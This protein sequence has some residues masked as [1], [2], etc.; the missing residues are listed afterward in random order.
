MKA[1]GTIL[2]AGIFASLS[3]PA[4]AGRCM[5]GSRDANGAPRQTPVVVDLDSER[6]LDPGAL[7]ERTSAVMCARRSIVPRPN[8]IRVLSEWNVAFGIAEEG[9]RRRNLWISVSAG[10]VETR[11]EGGELSAAER[12]AVEEWR[13]PANIRFLVER[14]PR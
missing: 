7:P 11:V 9:G 12:A 4:H 8:D 3:A 5:A 2:A 6:R 1:I 10:R 13:T 14:A